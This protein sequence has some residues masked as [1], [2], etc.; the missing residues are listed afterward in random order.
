GVF[1][2]QSRPDRD[3]FVSIMWSRI[4][5]K[6][7]GNFAKA[8]ST[9]TFD[10]PYDHGSVMHYGPNSFSKS[11]KSPTISAKDA[12]YFM[13]MGNREEPSFLD[14]ALVNQLY[15]CQDSCPPIDCDNG[16][17]PDPRRCGQCKCAPVF[18]G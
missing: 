6:W 3:D 14:V 11:P 8:R 4:R 17:Y 12:N 16:G 13:T 10:L 5:N 2:Q 18:T 15:S 9:N 7:E 1:H